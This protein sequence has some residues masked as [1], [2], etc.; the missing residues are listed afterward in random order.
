MDLNCDLGEGEP[1]T[2]TLALIRVITSAN[3]A[4]GGHAGTEATIR[5]GLRWCGEFGVQAGAH[6]GFE[7]PAH[8]GRRRIPLSPPDLDALLHRQLGWFSRVAAS[9]GLSVHHVKL[10]GALY[11]VVE[12]SVELA[13]CFLG[14]VKEVFPGRRVFAAPCGAVMAAAAGMEVEAWGE[15]FLDR[16]YE[17]DGRLV[18]REDPEALLSGKT[19]IA[20]RLADLARGRLRDREGGVL[21]FFGRTLCLHADTPDAVRI[22]RSAALVLLHRPAQRSGPRSPEKS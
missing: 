2:R 8:F 6:P 17:P 1:A 13:R 3:I 16:R 11:H 18:G 14:V 22:A 10:H 9:E 12:E 19:E 7:D 21:P 5:R 4:C 15:I 20:E